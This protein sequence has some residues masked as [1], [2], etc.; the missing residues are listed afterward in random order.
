MQQPAQSNTALPSHPPESP[1]R[2]G[3]LTQQ[4]RWSYDAPIAHAAIELSAVDSMRRIPRRFT[5]SDDSGRFH[6]DS[7]EAARFQVKVSPADAPS[8]TFEIDVANAVSG[9][10]VV[11]APQGRPS[12]GEIW[13]TV[14]ALVVYLVIIVIARWHHIARS[15]QAM[16]DRQIH[17]LDTRLTVEVQNPD[18]GCVVYLRGCVAALRKEE[19][20]RKRSRKWF[21]STTRFVKMLP[22]YF[23][24]SHG[25]ENA[26]WMAIH[27]IERQLTAFLSPPAHVD[28]Y[29]R[30]AC[31]ELQA[32]NKPVP[33]AMADAIRVAL[34]LPTPTDPSAKKERDEARKALLGRSVATL[35]VERDTSFSTLMEWHNKA[36]WLMLAAL[37]LIGLLAGTMGHAVLFLAGAAGGFVSRLMRA[38]KREDVPLDYGASWTTL[39]LSPLFGAIV[40][41]FGLVIIALAADPRVKLLGSAFQLVSWYRPYEVPALAVAFLLGFSERLFD[42]VV[43]ALEQ[44]AARPAPPQV[45][46]PSLATL[47]QAQTQPPGSSAPPGQGSTNNGAAAPQP[48]PGTPSA[49]SNT[50]TQPATPQP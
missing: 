47:A 35:Y 49:P 41:W 17:A 45:A 27:E 48:P 39:F 31:A 32:I 21:E 10:L 22:G 5:T 16:I 28:V 6:F 42:S 38:L 12:T 11:P 46:P 19:E 34:A 30:W 43:A 25:E 7:L 4:V 23:F 18:E 14:G 8:A 36:N 1:A 44:H 33:I 9:S 29:L 13:L 2:P 37:L 50:P 3:S 26:T 40:G 24:W 15:L 20:C